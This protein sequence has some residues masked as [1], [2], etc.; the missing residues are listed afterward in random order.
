MSPLV[1]IYNVISS[2]NN[3]TIEMFLP[4]VLCLIK[5]NFF[6][7]SINASFLP[8]STKLGNCLKTKPLRSANVKTGV[9]KMK[10]KNKKKRLKANAA[11]LTYGRIS[12]LRSREPTEHSSLEKYRD[13]VSDNTS[14]IYK[15]RI[16]LTSRPACLC[17]LQYNATKTGKDGIICFSFITFYLLMSRH[18]QQGPVCAFR[19]CNS[20][21][22]QS[23]TWGGWAARGGEFC[24]FAEYTAGRLRIMNQAPSLSHRLRDQAKDTR[25]SEPIQSLEVTE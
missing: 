3:W 22:L 11:S 14:N 18:S 12:V 13:T 1:N 9:P 17:Y 7:M 21:P 23:G 24:E 20:G 19:K 2:K 15:K 4:K 16:N 5:R 6:N 8:N 10:Q 25:S